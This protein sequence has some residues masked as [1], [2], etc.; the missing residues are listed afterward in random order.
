MVDIAV[1]REVITDLLPHPQHVRTVQQHVK[2]HVLRYPTQTSRGIALQVTGAVRLAFILHALFVVRLA[3]SY[4]AVLIGVSKTVTFLQ[5]SHSCLAIRITRVVPALHTITNQ[6]RTLGAHIAAPVLQNHIGCRRNGF[7]S[8]VVVVFQ[9]R[10]RRV[11]LVGTQTMTQVQTET[12]HLIL[13]QP[14]FQRT[15][16]HLSRRRETVIPVLVHIVAV[17]GFHIE[18]RVVRQV[19]TVRIELVHRIQTRRMVEHHIQNHGYTALVALVDKLL[20][21]RLRTIRLVRRE[22]VI[23]RVT[24]VVVAVKLTN[25]HQLHGVHTQVLDIIQPLHQALQRTAF[26]IVVYPQLIN[27][28]VVLVRTLE[29]ESR[30]RPLVLRLSGLDNGHIAIRTRRIVQQVRIHFLR[31]I[32]IVRMQHFLRIQIRDLLLHA[33]RTL[34][35]ILKTILLTGGQTRQRDPEIIAVLI[36]LIVSAQLPIRHIAQQEHALGRLRLAGRIRTQRH[37]RT[38]CSVI[39]TVTH[40]RRTGLLCRRQTG[41]RIPV[42]GLHTPAEHTQTDQT[43]KQLAHKNLKSKITTLDP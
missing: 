17:R 30:L 37:R 36:E 29:I 19:R 32:L 33:I 11:R 15:R 3:I 10:Y 42:G 34:H 16:K 38:I 5:P 21:H 2:R 8:V 39:D 27:H 4:I 6:L 41:Y 1:D 14:V 12:V 31:L 43:K 18:P 28:Q 7:D 25:R 23:R 40:S 35:S 26:C 22:I 20:V 13:R 9:V 24:P